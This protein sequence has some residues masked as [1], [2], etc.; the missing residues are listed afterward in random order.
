MRG[1]GADKRGVKRLGMC[2]DKAKRNVG[3]KIQVKL[4]FYLIFSKQ[5]TAVEIDRWRVGS[6]SE[7]EMK[8][9]RGTKL[10]DGV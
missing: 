3:K 5:E 4:E 6:Q 7:G 1:R 8:N 9:K 2:Q 10:I